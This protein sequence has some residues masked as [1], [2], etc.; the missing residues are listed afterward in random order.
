MENKAIVNK[1]IPFSNVDGPGNRLAIF[2]QGCNIRCI[3]CH[4]HET[5][6]NCIHCMDCILGCPT[7][8]IKNQDGR[9]VYDEDLCIACD[10]CIKICSHSASPRT[11]TYSAKELFEIVKGFKPY[12]RGITVSGGEPTLQHEVIADLFNLIK[13]LG[14]SCFVDTNGFFDRFALSKLIDATDKFM[15]DIK[16][17][18]QMNELCG[19]A[20]DE[21]L[22]NLNYLLQ[23]DKVYEVRTVI[24][25]GDFDFNNTIQKVAEMLQRYPTIPYRLIPV[26]TTGLRP[27]QRS[28]LEGNMPTAVY[29]EQ[30]ESEVEKIRK[31]GA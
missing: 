8:A 15:V 12:I 11:K 25:T 21:H 16:T 18:D 29:I 31:A 4:N 7:K 19:T 14:L 30:L 26:H 28:L 23:I 13:P 6:E 3:Y 5:L 27:E 1:I 9:I 17:V 24:L 20:L 2:T 22:D 10:Q